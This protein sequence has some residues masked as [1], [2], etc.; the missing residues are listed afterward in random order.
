MELKGYIRNFSS[1]TP[2][3]LEQ[4]K[5][6]LNIRMPLQK[7]AFCATYFQKQEK[8][9]PSIAELQFLDSFSEKFKNAPSAIA[10][11][12]L[13]TND[14][15]V[16]ETYAD[17]MQKRNSLH[18]NAKIPCT[19]SEAFGLA[20]NYLVRAGKDVSLPNTLVYT[21]ELRP[22]AP[23]GKENHLIVAR[24]TRFGIR[25]IKKKKHS[26]ND[27]D[28]L[29]LL[30]A[31]ATISPT[32]YGEALS[33]FLNTPELT[34]QIKQIRTVG[35]NGLLQEVLQMSDGANISLLRLARMGEPM[36][37]SMLTDAY[38]GDCVIRIASNQYKQIENAI[39]PLG[40]R[41][42]AFANATKN[43]RITAAQDATRSFSWSTDFLRALHPVNGIS[44]ELANERTGTPAPITHT[45]V[46]PDTCAY[47]SQTENSLE[48][49]TLGCND[50]LV[51]AATCRP[52]GAFFQNAFD[53]ALANVIK[54]AAAGCPFTEQRL[55]IVL[56]LPKTINT[57]LTAGEGMSAILGL[58]RLQTELGIPMCAGRIYN[59]SK[60]AHPEITVYTLADGAPCP[61]CFQKAN[62][63]I[64]CIA[65]A[66]QANGLPNFRELRKL[67]TFLTDLRRRNVLQSVRLI[68]RESVTTAL[69]SMRSE[70]LSCRM[71]GDVWAADGNIPLA[72]LLETTEAIDAKQVGIVTERD[73]AS[74]QKA[75]KQFVPR[76]QQIW[77]EV[78]RVVLFSEAW[79]TDAAMLGTIL[80][81]RGACV[82]HHTAEHLQTG[83]FSNDVLTSQTLIVCNGVT[84]PDDP[85]VR[86]ALDTLHRGGG[87]ILFPKQENI[88]TGIHGIALLEGITEKMLDQICILRK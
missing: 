53:T 42:L 10:P 20:S 65:P 32:Q 31:D 81:H 88:P 47:L 85:Y 1:Y 18:P 52:E 8:R 59:T 6:D 63:H 86:F 43:G 29:I 36:P 83:V 74:T 51:A 22:S 34:E 87:R 50:T 12:E 69:A 56:D 39:R 5:Q 13:L 23:V 82:L 61:S 62:D 2:Q 55:A 54:L 37:L 16:A 64:Y 38:V 21:E 67:L 3:Q 66:L 14:D 68:C 26:L 84:L 78:P 79:D 46:T 24:D 33:H 44:V 11:I 58:Y 76:E 4:M 48:T 40:L 73:S 7:L 57:P 17:M 71:T 70:K 77:S 75:Q 9:D 45:P 72:I 35:A 28:L 60:T 19:F 80:K 25:L 30:T 15:F 27:G 49:E 41:P